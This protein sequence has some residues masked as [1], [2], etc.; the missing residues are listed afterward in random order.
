MINREYI[1]GLNQWLS[2]QPG[3]TVKK[4]APNYY[5]IQIQ[6]KIFGYLNRGFIYIDNWEYRDTILTGDWDSWFLK[7]FYPQTEEQALKLVQYVEFIGSNAGLAYM[8]K[9]SEYENI[10]S[11]DYV[12]PEA[13]HCSISTF[14]EVLTI[15]I[16][17]KVFNLGQLSESQIQ[18]LK[19]KMQLF[20]LL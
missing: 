9:L 8:E 18:L 11:Y 6:G 5:S 1:I 2:Q 20:S 17:N 4:L 15:E 10:R 16:D 13:Y 19:N 12:L 3:S 7:L 14:G